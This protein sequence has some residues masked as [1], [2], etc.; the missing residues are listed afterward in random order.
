[1]SIFSHPTKS[2][3]S[4]FNSDSQANPDQNLK[5]DGTNN[6]LSNMMPPHG[7]PNSGGGNNPPSPPDA[8][9][10]NSQGSSSGPSASFMNNN[11]GNNTN[12]NHLAGGGG[13]NN[14]GMASMNSMA[15]MQGMLNP[16]NNMNN[17]NMPGAGGGAGLNPNDINSVMNAV[18]MNNAIQQQQQQQQQ[19]AGGM[20]GM[21][22]PLV[23]Q[24]MMNQGM[25]GN[26]FSQNSAPQMGQMGMNN[27]L[28]QGMM[29]PG[30]TGAAMG[31]MGGM[32]GM[33]MGGSM[34][35]G[36]MDGANNNTN[37]SAPRAN[38]NNSNSMAPAPTDKAPSSGTDNNNELFAQLMQNPMAA[39]MLAQG[40]NP[41]MLLGGMGG[42]MGQNQMGGAGVNPL[43]ALA[44][45]MNGLSSL[46]PGLGNNS[47]NNASGGPAD[48]ASSGGG[49]YHPMMSNAT[50]GDGMAQS[51]P[52]ALFAYN[53]SSIP[54]DTSMPA[55]G[56][57]DGVLKQPPAGK[58]SKKATKKMK[59]KGKPKRP[60][61]AYNFFF[62][63]ERGRILDSMPKAEKKSKKK[64][65][66]DDDDTKKEEGSDDE[67]KKEDKGDNDSKKDGKNTKGGKEY[68]Q[69]GTDGKKIP[70]GKIGF[71]NLA[72]LIG[73][74]WQELDADGVEKYKKLADQDMTRYKKEMEVF[75]T[76]EAQA[77]TTVDGELMAPSFY[78]MLNQ[79]RKEEGDEVVKPKKK[80]S[81][82]AKSGDTEVDNEPIEM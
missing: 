69:T 28:Q 67:K 6:M 60:L 2:N 14:N 55:M 12:L 66:D 34:Q 5:M 61:S 26:P 8:P 65:K 11:N 13:M 29:N 77:G 22:N 25:M 81:K 74:R 15:A 78:I 46:P 44:M 73:K 17:I 40:V 53:N 32:G 58:A 18:L 54:Q 27:L 71:E 19:A 48:V 38:D 16:N 59:V 41:M 7:V 49:L 68:D 63:E 56:A 9:S 37:A 24:T 30:M 3:H 1:M 10:R 36:G 79:K 47:A 31:M 42:G 76:K 4:N 33:G 39:Q 57:G 80:R 20:G 50:T 62:R 75:L 51:H 52:N 35:Q 72:K 23:L 45:G 64:K 70:H 21:M 43:G 82:K